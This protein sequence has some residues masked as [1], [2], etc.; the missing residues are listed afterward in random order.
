MI[1]C[2]KLHCTEMEIEYVPGS[3][4][5]DYSIKVEGRDIGVSVTRAM[6]F[7]KKNDEMFTE[8]DAERLLSKKLYGVNESTRGVISQSWEKQILHVWAQEEYM[9]DILWDTYER[10][11]QT[12]KSNTVVVVTVCHSAEWLFR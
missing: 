2:C 11:D 4:I 1:T 6:K 5:T 9:A 7:C 10:L 8:E 3:K 12:L